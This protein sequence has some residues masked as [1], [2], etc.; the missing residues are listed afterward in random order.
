MPRRSRA[1]SELDPREFIR[2]K[3]RLG[4]IGSGGE[5]GE[6]PVQIGPGIDPE[7][8]AGAEDRVEDGGTVAG[9]WVADKKPIFQTELTWANLPLGRII[10]DQEVA[11]ARVR[12]AGEF[13]PTGQ[14]VADGLAQAAL[15][16]Q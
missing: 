6:R 9:V 1:E 11:V 3:Q 5:A 10:V 15:D 8:F 12:E 4:V 16:R 7:E 13:R 14:G 2:G